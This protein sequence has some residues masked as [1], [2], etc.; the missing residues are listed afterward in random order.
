MWPE[1]S[2][3]VGLAL[4]TIIINALTTGPARADDVREDQW[5]LSE[6]RV[7][8]ANRLSTG[9]G[10]VVAVV[11]SG[12]DSHPDLHRNLLNGGS[13]LP[14]R[15]DTGRGDPNGHGTVMASLIAAHGRSNESGVAGIAPAAKILPVRDSDAEGRGNS[16]RSAEAIEWATTHG[17]KIINFSKAVSPSLALQ[18]AIKSTQA[19]DVLV[20][21]ASG[22]KGQDVVAAYPAEMPGVL[23][24]GA[25]GR[26]RKAAPF[27]KP[28]RN[29]QIC[30]PGV[31]IEGAKPGGKYSIGSGTSQ[32]TAIV[33]GAAALVRAKFP[34]L[35]AQQ[36]IA[37]L[38]STATDIGKPG[39]DNQCG[40][41]LLNIVAALTAPT[42]PQP[43]TS[44]TPPTTTPTSPQAAPPTPNPEPDPANTPLL[45]GGIIGA[46]A[47][48]GLVAFFLIRR[49]RSA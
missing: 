32:A 22:N 30:A 29:V 18:A 21:A 37:R 2:R 39:R 14:S 17:A 4:A 16:I 10:V 43:A 23:S 35:T 1:R 45:A 11:D 12:V 26:N 9:Q 42:T 41:G 44:P 31:D 8:E 48:T 13:V 28:G 24:V 36:V 46:L 19:S 15:L 20:I 6:L 38:T 40:Y 34:T 3:L 47:T 33:S 5:H 7:N 49:R 27:T 25:A